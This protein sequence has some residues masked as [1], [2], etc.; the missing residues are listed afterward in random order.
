MARSDADL[1][2]EER[3]AVRRWLVDNG[4]S[5]TP[6]DIDY[7]LRTAYGGGTIQPDLLRPAEDTPWWRRPIDL[8]MAVT[9]GAYGSVGAALDFVGAEGAADYLHDAAQAMR[10]Y[11]SPEQQAAVENLQSATG[12]GIVGAAAMNPMAALDVAGE[13]VAPMLAAPGVGGLLARA[14]PRALTPV[15][16]AALGEGGVTAVTTAGGLVGQDVDRQTALMTGLAAG[17]VGGGIGIGGGRLA[18]RFGAAD[19]ET[20]LMQ[21][22]QRR[23]RQAAGIP[24]ELGEEFL[25]EGTQ[26]AIT[27]PAAGQ[28]ITAQNILDAGLRG[29]VASVPITA[30]MSARRGAVDPAEQQ[31]EQ[32][33]ARGF[34]VV[35]PQK[36]AERRAQAEAA[37][38]PVDLGKAAQARADA[39]GAASVEMIDAA[40][41]LR[42]NEHRDRGLAIAEEIAGQQ[43]M[44]A[45]DQ[46]LRELNDLAYREQ[47]SRDMV[48]AVNDP[49]EGLAET[50]AAIN[51]RPDTTEQ[52]NML[53]A[54]QAVTREVN[55]RRAAE[56]L[57]EMGHPELAD[58]AL[59]LSD[60]DR[61]R[62][63]QDADLE[64]TADTTADTAP[65]VRRELDPDYQVKYLARR[66]LADAETRSPDAVVFSELSHQVAQDTQAVEEARAEQEGDAEKQPAVL[67]VDE[68]L[69]KVQL[70]K[71]NALMARGERAV[72]TAITAETAQTGVQNRAEALR[73]RI[74][75]EAEND[76][77]AMEAKQQEIIGRPARV[78]EGDQVQRGWRKFV[79]QYGQKGM[80]ARA[81]GDKWARAKRAQG[82]KVD[83]PTALLDATVRTEV[84][85]NE[86][87][88]KA[89][90]LA[91][92]TGVKADNFDALVDEQGNLRT[93]LTTEERAV[94]KEFA[95]GVQA[96]AQRLKDAGVISADTD[97]STYDAALAQLR[98]ATRA[99]DGGMT[100]VVTVATRGAEMA[101]RNRGLQQVTHW[102]RDDN[103]TYIV[104]REIPGETITVR[105]NGVERHYRTDKYIAALVQDTSPVDIPGW[106]AVTGLFRFVALNMNLG[107]QLANIPIDQIRAYVNDPN[108]RAIRDIP[109]LIGE[110]ANVREW[111]DAWLTTKSPLQRAVLMRTA[112]G[113]K[114]AALERIKM[115]EEKGFIPAES[116]AE[117]VRD[118]TREGGRD[119]ARLSSVLEG[120]HETEASFR[121]VLNLVMRPSEVMMQTIEARTRLAAAKRQLAREGE[122]TM[123]SVLRAR[124]GIG[125]PPTG[126]TYRAVSGA[127]AAFLQFYNA[128]VAGMVAD[129]RV[130]TNPE[131][132]KAAAL[133]L[134]LSTLAP[135]MLAMAARGGMFGGEDDEGWYGKW[136]R[137]LKGL[138]DY[139]MGQGMQIPFPVAL[140][141]NRE[142]EEEMLS[143]T[144]PFNRTFAPF[145]A[146]MA[147]TLDRAQMGEDVWQAARKGLIQGVAD[148]LPGA[149]AG[150]LIAHDVGTFLL[151]EEGNPEDRWGRKLFDTT[152]LADLGEGEKAAKFM[153]VH[154]PGRVGLG[155]VG[156]SFLRAVGR[157]DIAPLRVRAEQQGAWVEDLGEAPMVGRVLRRFVHARE[158]G[159]RE[160]SRRIGEMTAREQKAGGI[161]ERTRRNAALVQLVDEHP[162]PDAHRIQAA[163][164]RFAEGEPDAERM[165][166]RVRDFSKRA[167]LAYR[168]GA[169]WSELLYED[170]EAGVEIIRDASDAAR[171]AIRRW[172]LLALD[173]GAIAPSQYEEWEDAT[174]TAR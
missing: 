38:P 105:E 96:A 65:Q 109:V 24:I 50:L 69:H 110:L 2:R 55:T 72:N 155:D 94:Q 61:A 37:L 86:L 41:R 139:V 173:A 115:L 66:L 133:K 91:E 166:S 23:G 82:E 160:R 78:S 153:L 54:A 56:R 39:P 59:E 149:S 9:R 42:R 31:A 93:D 124:E 80:V 122:I 68:A 45:T 27:A 26:E 47:R 16:R 60:A 111:R 21:G 44:V 130:F 40:I 126:D 113:K 92:G 46:Q 4:R 134:T 63:W 74:R 158:A 147:S 7:V 51:A 49:N 172:L 161:D 57:R 118:P 32:E 135:A 90:T 58:R 119:V 73:N 129:A 107:W 121:R 101:R 14:A 136:V 142:G 64:V 62:V 117:F 106:K 5:S 29:M 67:A 75:R 123:E 157:E 8:G 104:G 167:L 154:L 156:A 53:D 89:V 1:D 13:S 20:L 25:Q 152:E 28:E 116:R 99:A 97:V 169:A 150:A 33:A 108:V 100:N 11:Q 146:A 83:R 132:S 128:I 140:R 163:A 103:R 151:T 141:T 127:P 95:A 174:R 165:E 30:A 3:E 170:T 35:E 36:R 48:R 15:A 12:L 114:R 70:D 120:G 76:V 6:D 148:S 98:A 43:G 71:L 85:Q 138:P 131:T 87:F 137:G 102:L 22:V 17:V 162:E 52:Q 81:L 10:E 84:T 145:L 19:P 164:R 88:G 79:T 168:Q 125:S 34:R 77:E 18:Q 112:V 159:R 144:L 143:F 171:P